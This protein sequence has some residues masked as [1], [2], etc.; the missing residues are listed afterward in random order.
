[1]YDIV[2]R[3]CLISIFSVSLSFSLLAEKVDADFEKAIK[4]LID[5]KPN[6][7]DAIHANLEDYSRDSILMRS[8]ESWSKKS[9]YPLGHAYALAHLGNIYLYHS[10]H[11]KSRAFHNEALEIAMDIDNFHLQMI[12]Y[13]ML[14]VADRRTDQIRSSI[15]LHQEAR[16]VGLK[17]KNPSKAVMLGIAT[18]ENSIGNAYTILGQH[19]QSMK[20]YNRA[21]AMEIKNE[22]LLGQ[23]INYQNIG[24]AHEELGRLDTAYAFYQKSLTANEKNNSEYGIIICYNSMAQIHNLK[25]EYQKA[26]EILEP[27]LPN[28]KKLN[29]P[30][31]TI[32]VLSDLGQSYLGLNKLE[33]AEKLLTEAYDISIEKDIEYSLENTFSLLSKLEAKKGNYKKALDFNIKSRT[34]N[35][36][37]VNQKNSQY[38]NDLNYKYDN[39]HLATENEII[40]LRLKQNRVIT[41][42]SGLCLLILSILTFFY[43]KTRQRSKDEMINSLK[44][45]SQIKTLE[46]LIE[47]EEKERNRIAK[48]LHDGL[49]GQLSAIKYK[50]SSLADE[51]DG[52]LDEVIDMIDDSCE[53][54]RTISHNLIPPSLENFDLI[55][56]A[57]DFCSYMDEAH[58]PEIIFQHMGDNIKI[59]KQV[60]INIYRI[61]QELVTNSIKHANAKEITVQLS[62]R[63]ELLQVT[64]EDD[65]NGFDPKQ[66]ESKGIGLKNIQSR[67]DYLQA[68]LDFNSNTQGTS[69]IIE[70]DTRIKHA[71]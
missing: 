26:I 4:T 37:I 50:L 45:E 66:I 25:E 61:I 22:N 42:I 35:D 1:M 15:D 8:L 47:G 49:N 34:Q 40:K 46:S 65:G 58:D 14:G 7:F 12:C 71:S 44:K 70:I 55:D 28:I 6:S 20:Y 30:F 59:D 32:F 21:L 52:A 18:S 16:T 57:E 54:V 43:F 33:K 2:I 67:V 29:D 10:S 19:E 53:Q 5:K 27:W 64:V 13:N 63:A 3:A 62:K 68:N 9:A 17:I 39:E 31:H 51:Q 56:A 41:F 38:I 24:Q 11:N 60:E 48:D 69:Y 23:A 36:K